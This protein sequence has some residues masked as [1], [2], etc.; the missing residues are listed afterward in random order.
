MLGVQKMANGH[1][2]KNLNSSIQ[3]SN[4]IF[5]NVNKGW[6]EIGNLNKMCLHPPQY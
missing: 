5:K 6:L 3:N 1:Y 2:I 4:E